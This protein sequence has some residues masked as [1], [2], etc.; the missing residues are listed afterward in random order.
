MT[1]S[2]TTFPRFINLKISSIEQIGNYK[3][4]GEIGRGSFGLI[5]LG[6]KARCKKFVV[7]KVPLH[8]NNHKAKKET[9][10]EIRFFHFPKYK[11]NCTKFYCLK[12]TLHT[13][14]GKNI[15]VLDLVDGVH[16]EKIIR[17]RRIQNYNLTS[18]L[19]KNEKIEFLN[20]LIKTLIKNLQS[21]H[22][23]GLS[24]GDIHTGNIMYLPAEKKSI[25]V[26]FGM[27]CWQNKPNDQFAECNEG[28][29]VGNPYFQKKKKMNA[30]PTEYK[31]F[32]TLKTHQADDVFALNNVIIIEIATGS[33][34]F[35]GIISSVAVLQKW[36]R[37]FIPEVI[38]DDE[39]LLKEFQMFK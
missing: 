2:R 22:R 20:T 35:K 4:Y 27:A 25:L 7:L 9:E 29:S 30:V 28:F 33:S 39:K 17:P 36:K 14:G 21:F 23:L 37:V 5:L 8:Y 3:I 24:H 19:T 34:I 18:S 1:T 31:K 16:L 26:D 11:K 12:E 38:L 15:L 13:K 6:K 32:T 10:D